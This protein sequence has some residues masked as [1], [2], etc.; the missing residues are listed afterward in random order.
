MTGAESWRTP[1]ITEAL[2]RLEEAEVALDRAIVEAKRVERETPKTKLS[3]EDIQLIEEHARSAEAP[4]ELRE[5]QRRIDD[6]ELS[7]EDVAAGRRLDDPQVRA[8]LSTGVE[9][10]RQA[11][12]M[13]QEG[14]ELD[15]IIEQGAPAP[16][17]DDD[18]APTDDDDE[19]KGYRFMRTTDE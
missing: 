12:T 11:Y 15:D 16:P 2:A 5:L 6:G 3:E 4:R 17:R 19:G 13:I 7:W 9:G 14:H 10:M 18:G 8:A 1:Q